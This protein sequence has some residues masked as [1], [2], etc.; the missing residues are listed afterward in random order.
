MHW[1]QYDAA[2]D[3][4]VQSRGLAVWPKTHRG[5]FHN[6]VVQKAHTVL[7]HLSSCFLYARF[8]YDVRVPIFPSMY[9]GREV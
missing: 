5:R 7:W 2:A 4:V 8:A 9:E 6:R 1:V 3:A